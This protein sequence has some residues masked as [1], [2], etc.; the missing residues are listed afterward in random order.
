MCTSLRVCTK[1]D[2]DKAF[3]SQSLRVGGFTWLMR[4]S[5]AAPVPKRPARPARRRSSCSKK[6]RPPLSLL[7]LLSG[8]AALRHTL[9]RF[10][11][12]LRDHRLH[13]WRS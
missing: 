11:S 10:R 13:E 4:A 5:A 1:L 9:L 12:G 7:L 8:D 2:E 3:S 6:R